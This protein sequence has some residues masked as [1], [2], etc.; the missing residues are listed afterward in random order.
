MR[1]STL[2]MTIALIGL[3]QLALGCDD[4][5]TVGQPGPRAAQTSRGHAH[6]KLPHELWVTS[7]GSSVIFIR[8]FENLT[9]IDQFYL[10]AGAGPHII[11]FHSPDFAYVGGMSD[12]KVYVIDARTRHVAKSFQ[13]APTL[14]H[15]VKVSPD[16]ATALVSIIGNTSIDGSRKVTRMSVDEAHRAWSV[17]PS[18]DIGAATGRAP[19]CTVFSADSKRAF[20]SLLPNGIAVVDV[21]SM[22]FVSQIPTDGFIACGMIKS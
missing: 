21:D 14:V 4:A 2:R 7:Q 5:T 16:G 20:V 22:R 19:V 10:P 13:L 8:N 3:G 6:V 18:L 17:G 12:G 15:Q 11:T 9:P 1:Q